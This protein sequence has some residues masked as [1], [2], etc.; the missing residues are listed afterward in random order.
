MPVEVSGHTVF[1]SEY[2]RSNETYEV[3][4]EHGSG[5]GTYRYN[6]MVMAA[7]AQAEPGKKFSHWER[8]GTVVSYAE[9]Y[10]FYGQWKHNRFGGLCRGNRGCD[11]KADS[12]HEHACGNC[13]G[14]QDCVFCGT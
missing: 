12:C 11:K 6:D 5:S 13:R 1:S 14:K 8:G 3:V 10:S 2:T 4:V 7:A 9:K